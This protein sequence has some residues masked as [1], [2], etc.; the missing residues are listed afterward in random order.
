MIMVLTLEWI[1]LLFHFL[2]WYSLY[3]V[4]KHALQELEGKGEHLEGTR[5]SWSTSI[6]PRGKPLGSHMVS[7]KY[8]AHPKT[9]TMIGRIIGGRVHHKLSARKVT[10]MSTIP[11]LDGFTSELP[12]DPG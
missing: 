4:S 12:I 2:S 10:H 7:W 9:P 3:V 6:S 8:L 11:A 1:M 5:T